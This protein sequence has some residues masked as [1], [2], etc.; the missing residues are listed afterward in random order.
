MTYIVHARLRQSSQVDGA[1][2][3]HATATPSLAAS[4]TRC[5]LIVPPAHHS[6]SDEGAKRAS[7]HRVRNVRIGS[8]KALDRC[9]RALLQWSDRRS[10]RSG[11]T[12]C[13][14]LIERPEQPVERGAGSRQR[15]ERSQRASLLR[16]ANRELGSERGR[17]RE[18]RK[19]RNGEAQRSHRAATTGGARRRPPARRAKGDKTA[20]RERLHVSQ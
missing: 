1:R 14:R 15:L 2:R 3:E 6:C 5:Q 19:L 9:A 7:Q 13:L 20:G 16:E 12:G 17:A 4:L 10:G 8:A 18:P 11:G